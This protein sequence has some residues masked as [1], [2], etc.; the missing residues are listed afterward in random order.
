MSGL[1]CS[2]GDLHCGSWASLASAPR[3]HVAVVQGRIDLSSQTRGHT[4]VPC[5]RPPGKSRKLDW[6]ARRRGHPVPVWRAEHLVCAGLGQPSPGCSASRGAMGKPAT[7]RASPS[8][9]R[10]RV[11]PTRGSQIWKSKL[12]L[13]SGPQTGP[14]VP[15]VQVFVQNRWGADSSQVALVVK[16]PPADAGRRKRRGFNPWVGKIPWRRAW[17]PPPVFLP[18]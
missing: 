2:T 10:C 8:G 6:L 13:E 11:L 1:G 4:Y 3:L 9:P 5:T 18:G 16:N 17:Q 15:L 14:G 7:R 12:A